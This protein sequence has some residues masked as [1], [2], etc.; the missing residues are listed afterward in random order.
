MSGTQVTS[1]FNQCCKGEG[2]TQFRVAVQIQRAG[3]EPQTGTLVYLFLI[4]HPVLALCPAARQPDGIMLV[5]V[6]TKFPERVKINC[7]RPIN[8]NLDRYQSVRGDS[9]RQWQ[10]KLPPTEPHL[11][12]VSPYSQLT[13]PPGPLLVSPLPA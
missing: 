10:L 4:P 2:E 6:A 8:C 11:Q 9:C 5:I 12:P 3:V 7:Q 1:E 13:H